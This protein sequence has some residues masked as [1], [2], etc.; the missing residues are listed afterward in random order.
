MNS[1]QYNGLKRLNI[2][3]VKWGTNFR[4]KV[5]NQYGIT[6]FISKVSNPKAVRMISKAYRLS[7][8]RIKRELEYEYRPER[9]YKKFQ[10]KALE[11]HEF[12][13]FSQDELYEKVKTFLES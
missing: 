6:T 4:V 11:A 8:K 5:R 7:E 1:Q 10:G 9:R 12:G 2:P 3:V 13:G